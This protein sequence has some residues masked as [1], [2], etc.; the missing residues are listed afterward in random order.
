MMSKKEIIIDLV[1]GEDGVFEAPKS[2]STHH[3]KSIEKKV[4]VV[5]PQD[6]LTE[7]VDGYEEGVK[8][9]KNIM[10]AFGVK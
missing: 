10:K 4:K 5:Q 1:E 3:V 8:V 6:P 9:I 7:L 2:L